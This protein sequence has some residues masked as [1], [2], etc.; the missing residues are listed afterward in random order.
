MIQQ[1]DERSKYEEREKK[2]HQVSSVHQRNFFERNGCDIESNEFIHAQMVLDKL[3]I[4][5]R[6]LAARKRDA[7][8]LAELRKPQEDSE[9]VI[10]KEFPMLE[11]LPGL[12]LTGKALS[13]LLMVFEF[14]HNFG[15]TLGFGKYSIYLSC[16][17]KIPRS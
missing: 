14:L 10:Q 9:L 13:D 16:Q 17:W 3:I 7:E 1:L 4:R 12:K 15:E 2:K 11:R 5:E 8:I 6:K